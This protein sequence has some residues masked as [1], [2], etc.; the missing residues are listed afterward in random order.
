M[1]TEPPIDQP[2]HSKVQ[3]P[4]RPGQKQNAP[5]NFENN[6]RSSTNSLS[7]ASTDVGGAQVTPPAVSHSGVG[8]SGTASERMEFRHPYSGD[9]NAF[10]LGRQNWNMEFKDA[11]AAAQAAAESAERASMAA[12]A[13]AELSSRGKISRQYSTESQ[14]SNI[15]NSRDEGPT[16]N[17]ASKLA[18]EYLAKYSGYEHENP[19]ETSEKVNV[20]GHGSTKRS[21]QSASLRSTAASIDEDKFDLQTGDRHSRK[22]SFEEEGTKL[23]KSAGSMKKQSIGSEVEFV[24][25]RQSDDFNYFAEERIGKQTSSAS[26]HSHSSNHG[27]DDYDVSPSSH[28]KFDEMSMKKESIGYGVEFASSRQGGLQ[29]DGFNYFG[30]DRIRKQTSSASSHS[31]SG[32]HDDDYDVSPF[33]HPKFD[34]ID[35]GEAPFV[36]IGQGYVRDNVSSGSYNNAAEVFDAFV[37]D[38]DGFKFDSGPK[39][40]W[41]E[42]KS[43][44]SPGREPHSHLPLNADTWSLPKSPKASQPD[45]FL[46][47]TFDESEGPSSESEDEMEKHIHRGKTD[48]TSL[49][50]KE[51]ISFRNGDDIPIESHGLTGSFLTEKGDS[52]SNRKQD[53]RHFS[54]DNELVEV[55]AENNQGTE[56]GAQSHRKF[57]F[58]EVPIRQSSAKLAKSQ[59]S[60]DAVTEPFYNEVEERKIKQS[61]QTSRLSFVNEVK[62]AKSVGTPESYYNTVKEEE[63]FEHSSLDS[64]KEF[65]FGTLTGGLRNKGYRQPPYTRN[66]SGDESSSSS[67]SS[68]KVAE[69]GLSS[70]SYSKSGVSTKVKNKSSSRTL[71]TNYDSDTDDSDEEPPQ[72]NLHGKRDPESPKASKKEVNTKSRL[73]ASATFFDSDDNDS[74]KDLPKQ[75]S[76]V[77]ARPGS[78]LSRRTKA[79]ASSGTSSYSRAT[80]GSEASV[81]NSEANARKMPSRSSYRSET[82][83]KSQAQTEKSGDRENSGASPYSKA[84]VGSEASA[85]DSEANARKMPSRS[86]YRSKTPPKLQAQT[87]KS[88]H[89]ELSPEPTAAKR[90]TS[91]PMPESYISLRKENL[92]NSHKTLA[93]AS[94]ETPKTSTSSREALS[95]ESSFTKAS[96]VHPK[97]PDYDTIAAQL[98]S[99]RLNRQ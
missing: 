99:L 89:R 42:S 52:G 78:G 22:S 92:T 84:S 74:E 68:K 10:S 11:T 12:R 39:Y 6:A 47:V 56:F 67:S 82:P 73:R 90:S 45:D 19:N 17:A 85:V 81:L 26:S 30:E 25:T 32:N 62:T 37:P 3:A 18:N 76:T 59:I 63:L 57:G 34:E 44:A 5:V 21:S 13:A 1:Q 46:P 54:D 53:V 55:M 51:T 9:G 14:T 64:G 33:S 77:T 98:Q 16:K 31:H 80:V 36:S 4:P 97:L 66:P 23:E 91:E 83:P 60:N 87:A 94:S 79:T 40:D 24:S 75:T 49:P 95:R 2:L 15:Y 27:D 88:S 20:D 93:S 38:D 58:D 8:P 50:H 43:S 7:F 70:N 69:D 96:H 41:Q 86:S 72:Q 61:R 48:P 71:V 65:N 28:P 29:S 35:G